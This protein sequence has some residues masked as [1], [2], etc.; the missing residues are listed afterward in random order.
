MTDKEQVFKGCSNHNC[1]YTVLYPRAP[2]AMGTNGS[3]RCD[4]WPV[5][6]ALT[7]ERDDLKQTIALR[8][9]LHAAEMRYLHWVLDEYKHTQQEG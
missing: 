5:I 3:C 4:A 1:V 9:V 7:K 2:S 6:R 8:E